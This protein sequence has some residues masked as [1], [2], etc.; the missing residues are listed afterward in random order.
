MVLDQLLLLTSGV[1][2][3][4]DLHSAKIENAWLLF[5]LMTG[6]SVRFYKE[7][8]KMLF[9]F[10]TGA[11]L[12]FLCLFLLFLIRALGAG[13][14]KLLCVL[15]GMLGPQKILQGMWYA[16]MIGAG[17]SMML[18]ISLGEGKERIRYFFRY[19]R[20][21]LEGEL[22]PYGKPGMQTEKIHFT[23]PVFL[24]M[25]LHAGGVF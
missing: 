24:S 1:A 25:V 21:L 23:I 7:G 5:M 10:G 3:I 19:C 12:P 11:L 16:F 2:V 20:K 15:G 17:I 18:L 9:S 13:D 6:F 8:W 22:L 14:V 4:M